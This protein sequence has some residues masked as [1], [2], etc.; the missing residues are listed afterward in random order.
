[1]VRRGLK[2]RVIDLAR[3]VLGGGAVSVFY[4]QLGKALPNG[5]IVSIGEVNLSWR[6]CSGQSLEGNAV[7]SL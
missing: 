4:E 1:M 2:G 5:T 7:L 6:S 3:A